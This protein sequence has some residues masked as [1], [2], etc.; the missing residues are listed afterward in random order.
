MFSVF[1]IP[2]NH[3]YAVLTRI[4]RKFNIA[5]THYLLFK[6]LSVFFDVYYSKKY[7]NIIGVFKYFVNLLYFIEQ[8]IGVG[9][10]VFKYSVKTFKCIKVAEIFVNTEIY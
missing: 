7:L 1:S 8:S 6:Y 2:E 9:I 4:M 3:F 5:I 10:R